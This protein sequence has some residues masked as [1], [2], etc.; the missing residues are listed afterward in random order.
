MFLLSWREGSTTRTNEII[1]LIVRVL[2]KFFG[3]TKSSNKFEIRNCNSN[4][5]NDHSLGACGIA[6]NRHKITVMNKRKLNQPTHIM[7]SIYSDRK[8]SVIFGGFTAAL[9]LILAVC[10]VRDHQNRSEI[11]D[12]KAHIEELILIQSERTIQVDNHSSSSLAALSDASNNDRESNGRLLNPATPTPIHSFTYAADYGVVGNSVVDDTEA[13]QRAI[14]DA[15]SNESAFG[16]GGT[17]ILPRGVFLT[18]SPLVIPGG[19]TVTGQGYGSSPLAIQFDAGG[20]VIA[21]CGTDYAVKFDGHSSSLN[22]VA[23]YDWRYPV[24]SAC[25]EMKAQGGVLLDADGKLL[26]SI[27]MSNVLI[28]WFMGGTSLTLRARN[29]GG[30]AFNNFQNIRVRHAYKGISLEAEDGSFVK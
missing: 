28:Y 21:Y 2:L 7:N 12:L 30:V 27:T 9:V 24:G 15:A 3:C 20:S 4:C 29:N 8:L 11:D 19:V 1:I 18:T 17:V 23:V 16:G 6:N 26:E 22:N 13:L 14:D 10:I 5:Q 25:D